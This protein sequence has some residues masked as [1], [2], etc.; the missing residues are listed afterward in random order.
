MVFVL[1][2]TGADVDDDPLYPSGLVYPEMDMTVAC[3]K[4]VTSCWFIPVLANCGRNYRFSQAV[5]SW[6]INGKCIADFEDLDKQS[7]LKSN[8]P[9][10]MGQ[11]SEKEQPKALLDLRL[12]G[13]YTC[14]GPM[15]TEAS[16]TNRGWASIEVHHIIP[17]EQRVPRK[18]ETSSEGNLVA[19]HPDFFY[20]PSRGEATHA[21]PSILKIFRRS[22]S[23]RNETRSLYV[24]EQS[25][26]N[27]ITQLSSP[28]VITFSSFGTVDNPV[29]LLGDDTE[30][31]VLGL[32]GDGTVVEFLPDDV[33]LKDC[34]GNIN[35][36]TV[37]DFDLV[38]GFHYL[39]LNTTN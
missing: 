38:D 28:A 39:Q 14:V 7:R 32:Y 17:N 13:M 24:S 10:G 30:E 12:S 11:E 19:I 36:N 3:E 20:P 35:M 25:V 16:H 2:S 37:G 23:V 31:R 21:S 6:F 33:F 29:L 34:L 5:F 4:A 22:N 27:S 8:K 9:I 1:A 18:Y 26:W 15:Y